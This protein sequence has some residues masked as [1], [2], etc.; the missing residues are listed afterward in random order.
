[1][2]DVIRFQEGRNLLEILETPASEALVS[3]LFS[4]LLTFSLRPW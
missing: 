1:V 3:F 2:I 4:F